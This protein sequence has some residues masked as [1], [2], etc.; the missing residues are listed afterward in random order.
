M[1]RE[2]LTG[3]SDSAFVP[4]S[5][6][7]ILRRKRRQAWSFPIC[8]LCLAIL[9]GIAGCGGNGGGEG[10]VQYWH[11]EVVVPFGHQP[12]P[13]P[14]G[15][16]IAFGGMGDSTGIWVLDRDTNAITRLTDSAHPHRWDYRWMPSSQALVFGGAGESGTTTT[17]IWHVTC[18]AG[19]IT[20]LWQFGGDPDPAPNGQLVV[21]AGTST[22][23]DEAGIWAVGVSVPQIDRLT[24]VG[25]H[26]RYSPSGLLISYT[27]PIG[28]GFPELR[29]MN[30]DGTNDRGVTNDILSQ[31]WLDNATLIC[32]SAQ[33]GV[34]SIIQVIIGL[35][36]QILPVVQGGSQYAASNDL[37]LIVFQREESG[38]SLGLHLTTLAGGG[39]K[40]IRASGSYPQF[41]PSSATSGAI[42][43]VFEDSD[44]ILIAS[45]TS[46]ASP[47]PIGLD[48]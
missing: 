26:P 32:S 33:G 5:R 28:A 11:A 25:T 4:G 22:Q 42:D 23:S 3:S 24:Q 35:T 18:P 30:Q 9:L 36:P 29:V 16:W 14:D 10:G 20:Q 44:G 12:M 48:P 15:R 21:L 41:L 47:A 38:E 2:S 34:V 7:P 17:G 19:V 43:V 45:S 39:S 37:G 46:G 40:P 31:E 13:S 1:I 27:V 6:I 8:C